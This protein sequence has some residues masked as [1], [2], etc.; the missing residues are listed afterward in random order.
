M[1]PF[2]ARAVYTGMKTATTKT[3][4]TVKQIKAISPVWEK[5][6]AEIRRLGCDNRVMNG[7][8]R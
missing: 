3:M 1:Q 4:L 5:M 7:A 2:A 6:R 8:T